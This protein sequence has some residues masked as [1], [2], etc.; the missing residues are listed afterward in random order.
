M[1]QTRTRRSRRWLVTLVAPAMALA[2]V[3]CSSSDSGGSPDSSEGTAVTA[4]AVAAQIVSTF[5]AE[6]VP[7]DKGSV[8]CPGPLASAVGKTLRC[9]FTSGDQPVGAV[10]TVTKVDGSAVGFDI[11]AEARPVPQAII[12]REVVSQMKANGLTV[13]SAVC[14][15]ELPA[16]AGS[17]VACT[18]TG[19]G[20]SV[21]VTARAQS[22]DGGTVHITI[23]A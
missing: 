7:V 16:K 4:D 22:I 18:A 15:G 6:K 8:T 12:E 2:L 19:G 5:A 13:D 21:D 14:K 20:E 1:T 10:A 17:T 11:T 23:G 9:E 3:G